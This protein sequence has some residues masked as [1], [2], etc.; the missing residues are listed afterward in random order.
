M[1]IAHV[2]FYASVISVGKLGK[3][4]TDTLVASHSTLRSASHFSP[5]TSQSEAS[6]FLSG[7]ATWA[8]TLDG[9]DGSSR[10]LLEQPGLGRGIGESIDHC[11]ASLA[12]LVCE[13]IE[14]AV[15]M[16]AAL[17]LVLSDWHKIAPF[18]FA[19]D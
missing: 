16:T 11:L 4:G 17:P 15:Q 14:V 6:H 9:S 8:D 1:L 5:S 7:L 2:F 10:P 19:S 18:P 3:M 12:G 13:E